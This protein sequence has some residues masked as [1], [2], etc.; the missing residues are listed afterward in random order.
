MV[1]LKFTFET[2]VI[3]IPIKST[4]VCIV[5]GCKVAIIRNFMIASFLPKKVRSGG[6]LNFE[7]KHIVDLKLY[8]VIISLPSKMYAIFCIVL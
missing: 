8:I 2:A 5:S 6:S 3:L 4:K 7:K 1:A